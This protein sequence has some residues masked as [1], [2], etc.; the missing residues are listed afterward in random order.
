MTEDKEFEETLEPKEKDN[1]IKKTVKIQKVIHKNKQS[2]YI[3]IPMEIVDELGIKKGDMFTFE[4][5]LANNPKEH[6]V[7]FRL[8]G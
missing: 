4:I 6:K 3:R 7:K 2:F 1:K 5:E 8:G